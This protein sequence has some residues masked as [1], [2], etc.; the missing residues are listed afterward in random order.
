MG[1][2]RGEHLDDQGRRP[3]DAALTDDRQPVG[4]DVEDV[5]LDHRHVAQD[6]VRRRDEDLAEEV[7]DGTLTLREAQYL[8]ATDW[9][10]YY[11]EKVLN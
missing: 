9:F 1:G 2:G 3:L 5:W 7:C 8:I 4:G 6:A 10:K 11:R